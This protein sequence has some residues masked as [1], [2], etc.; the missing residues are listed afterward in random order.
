MNPAMT[1]VA[2]S[3]QLADWPQY[4][5]EH[6]TELILEHAGS[7]DVRLETDPLRTWLTDGATALFRAVDAAI[8]HIL[9]PGRPYQPLYQAFNF[10]SVPPIGCFLYTA[11]FGTLR[12]TLK[13]FQCSNPTWMR[14]SQNAADLVSLSESD[15]STGFASEVLRLAQMPGI[16]SRPKPYQPRIAHGNSCDIHVADRS[17]DTVLTS[18]PY[19][20]RI[21]YAVATRPELALMGCSPNE[22]RTLR[23]KLMGSPTVPSVL[24]EVAQSWGRRCTAF[25]RLV[26]QHSSK[27]SKSYYLKTYLSYFANLRISINEIS[28]VLKPGGHAAVVLQDSYYKDIHTDLPSI[29]CEMSSTAGL[30]CLERRDFVV[31]RTMRSINAR[32]K[33]YREGSNATESVILFQKVTTK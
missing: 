32:A 25:L 12:Q 16:A 23:L 10:A 31:A 24:P 7:F 27:A 29:F 9:A 22:F 19:C 18:P 5:L 17:V 6:L 20:T 15:L 8:Q 30:S 28:R 21:D 26:E 14:S 33:K 11:L 1:I 2:R 4:P 3:R 13:Q